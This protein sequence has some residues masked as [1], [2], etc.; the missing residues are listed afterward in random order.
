MAP[1]WQTLRREFPLLDRVIYLNACSL[2]P[3]PRRGREALEEYMTS[4]E[5][6]GTPVWFSH[7]L[8]ALA[9]LRSRLA[10]LLHAAPGS[11]ALAPSTSAALTT[12][13]SCIPRTGRRKVLIGELDFPTLGHQW[14]SRPEF[15]VE[16]VRST[17]GV[18]ISPEAFADRIDETTALVATTHVFYT[19][20]YLQDVRAL[21]EIAHAKGALLLVDGYQSV[22]CVPVDVTQL[23]CDIFVGGCLKWLS[24]GPGTAFMY[25]KP[26]LSPALFPQGTGWFAT[27]SPFSFTLERVEFAEDA[28]RFESGTWPVPSHVAAL[29]ALEIV[30]EV[31]VENIRSRLLQLTQRILDFCDTEGMTALTPRADDERAGIVA[32]GCDRAEEVESRLLESQVVVDSR[33]GRVRLSPHWCITEAE[34]DRAL[35]AIAGLYPQPWRSEDRTA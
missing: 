4:W 33:P 9:R 10:Q 25:V 14:L 31:G 15:E 5:E 2:G 7:W 19:T 28:R 18:T 35:D 1:D 8:P 13:A 29:A 27:Q 17:D 26:D 23:A 3:L 32:I 12:A 30:L 6:I 20:G 11:V 16:F 24:G 34:L 21:A 22:G